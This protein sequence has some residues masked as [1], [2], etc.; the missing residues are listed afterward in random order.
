MRS[1]E[2]VFKQVLAEIRNSSRIE[3]RLRRALFFSAIVY[4]VVGLFASAQASNFQLSGR[5][6]VSPAG[7]ASYNIPLPVP[8]GTAG[9]QPSIGLAYSSGSGSGVTGIGWALTGLDSIT[10]CPQ[11]V[12][13]DGA[14]IGV[15]Y[16]DTDR[17]CLDGQRLMRISGPAYGGD[18]TV[19]RT[20]IE[21]FT[22]VIS[23]GVTGTGPTWFEVHTKAGQTM[24]FGRTGD[25]RI[26][27][28]GNP[29][30]RL[31]ALD[32]V[33]DTVGNYLTV[34][35]NNQGHASG[36]FLP[37]EIDYTGNPNVGTGQQP[38][39]AV[40]FTYTPV[41]TATGGAINP[42]TYYQ[43][44]SAYTNPFLLTTISTY[45]GTALVNNYQLTYSAGSVA[46]HA[47]LASVTACDNG[48]GANAQCLLPT[49]FGYTNGN[50]QSD[51]LNSITTGLGAVTGL[52]YESIA[53]SAAYTKGQSAQWPRI[54][55]QIPM[56]VVT[57]QDSSNGIGGNYSSTYAYQGAQADLS[58]HGFQGF[59]KVDA[60]DLQ[61]NL[62]QHSYYDQA[63]P[64]TGML[65]ARTKYSGSQIV[66]KVTNSYNCINQGPNTNDCINLTS[67][68]FL[69]EVNTTTDSSWD[70]DGTAMPVLTTT[71]DSYDL[72][73]N[74]LSITASTPDGYAKI[75]TSTYTNDT[76]NWFI[77]R[78]TDTQVK[79]TI[80]GGTSVTRESAWDYYPTV[81]LLKSETVEPN[82]P[83]LTLT[84]QY[85]Y[86]DYGN[87]ELT[88]VS[89]YEVSPRSTSV[90]WG[91]QYQGRFPTLTVNAL[92]QSEAREFDL[93]FGGNTKLTDVNGLVTTWAYDTLGRKTDETHNPTLTYPT[94]AHWSY[95]ATS[96][97]FLSCTVVRTATGQPYLKTF[98][99]MLERPAFSQVPAFNG[100]DTIV[101]DLTAYNAIGQVRSVAEPYI[102]T[103]TDYTR[104]TYDALGRVKTKTNP[105]SGV[106]TYGYSGLVT[107]VTDPLGNVTTTQKDSQ[108]QVVSVTDATGKSSTYTYKPFG[109]VDTV[110]DPAGN[111]ATYQYDIR[112]RATQKVDPDL[113]LWQYEYDAL[114]QVEKQTDAKLQVTTFTYDTLSR[115]TQR[116]EPDLTS[117]WTYDTQPYGVGKLA[118]TS[119]DGDYS[120]IE[121]YDSYGRPSIT[122]I[123]VA[124][125]VYNVTSQY[126]T[127]SRVA[128]VFY[129]AGTDVT[130]GNRFTV[131]YNYDPTTSYLTSLT[132]ANGETALWSATAA[133]ASLNITQE[134]AGNG[135]QTIKTYDN[136]QRVKTIK[137]GTTIQNFT[138][139]RDLDGNLTDRIDAVNNYT[140]N[141]TYDALNRLCTAQINATR[142]TPAGAGNPCPTQPQSFYPGQSTTYS[143]IGNL[144]YKS[145][146]GPYHYPASGA[147]SSLPHAVSQIGD[148]NQ[149]ATL[150]N[151][152]G[153]TGVVPS[154]ATY[155]YDADGNMTNG[156]GRALA[157]TSYNMPA[158]IGSGLPNCTAAGANTVMF[159]YDSDHR[160]YKEIAPAP[161]P[162]WTLVSMP[163]TGLNATVPAYH[164]ETRVYIQTA[165]GIIARAVISSTGT[166]S[167]SSYFG[168]GEVKGAYQVSSGT[169]ST[170]YY[171]HDHL[172]SV[173]ALTGSDGGV[174]ARYS[175]DAWGKFRNH[176]GS[177]DPFDTIGSLVMQ[178][179]TGQEDLNEVALINL[180]ARVYD[181]QIGK[182]TSAD[183]MVGA[184][185]GTQGWNRY[186]YA[187]NNPLVYTDPTGMCFLGCFWKQG[188]FRDIVG[189]A[190]AFIGQEYL[191]PA[192]FGIDGIGAAIISGAAAGGITSGSLSGVLTGGIE[193]GLFFEVGT[194]T[195]GHFDLGT[196]AGQEAAAKYFGT[197]NFFENVAGHAVVGG[198]ANLANGASFQSGFVAA[199]FS[200]F[201]GPGLAA[202][203][204]DGLVEEIIAGGIGSELGGGKFESGA[205]T[206]AFGYLFNENGCS[207]FSGKS[208]EE[209]M[210]PDPKKQWLTFGAFAS[211]TVAPFAAAGVVEVGLDGAG[212]SVF[213]SGGEEALSVARPLG[214]TL[215]QT[216]IGS[217]LNWVDQYVPVPRVVW[218]MSSR[219]FADNATGEATAVIR[220]SSP[221]SIWNTIEKPTLNSNNVPIN[222]K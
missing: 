105:D 163:G 24:E 49:A 176:D 75:T 38:Y 18:G 88:Q 81:G 174:L 172:G 186:A 15:N 45:V 60:T 33:T 194:L 170:T 184:M 67:T 98:Y 42:V 69:I 169:A 37:Q 219:I 4:I 58:G 16:T 216:P 97:C 61:T 134:T 193:A 111:Q 205:I 56:S 138:Y 157:Y 190:V 146:A 192:W 162:S 159:G 125:T 121:S 31:W 110:T 102:G 51:L 101:K 136:M 63:F 93:R 80:P 73:G 112:G 133:N 92:G 203:N 27:A 161:N 191:L 53:N 11:T 57:R 17:F 141:F 130:G 188:W 66:N 173:T 94:T 132:N 160:R 150:N 187:G 30:A 158:C 164:S 72:F 34:S 206:G 152:R 140:E 89:G 91:T 65:S 41:N 9:M 155:S 198:L 178:T 114:S 2:A 168:V 200:D 171:H 167:W 5:F 22:E 12:A 189:I 79:A 70:L 117:T 74:P 147:G 207:S 151:G 222:Y 116:V 165:A 1:M 13:Q 182:F 122:A 85:Y 156:G 214:T 208:Y 126:D 131:H 35:Y 145:D 77:G 209:C 26:L 104:Y 123:T 177:A 68:R 118:T 20:E 137:T 100:T 142:A 96:G 185:F 143:T 48:V 221:K 106:I 64:L 144:N 107:S 202:E 166:V 120:R 175:Y 124:G 52:T 95:S 8:P 19:Y 196:Q 32:R 90:T 62:L 115:I 183:P 39:A 59:A 43:A 113:G 128:K 54:D 7:A 127:A 71:Y 3:R 211:I 21:T 47:R 23:H 215:D 195:N 181:P 44:G 28:L 135:V 46:F 129:P 50:G 204:A 210:N 217:F 179:Y 149:P 83:T 213:W 36:Y 40:K 99:D 199:G 6:N 87:K 218:Q 212:T 10:R 103:A 78:V 108:S 197:V 180:N 86:D 119:T 14:K 153:T 220:N 76:T 201:V 139:D 84:T 82:N 154:P 148:A 29:T 25:S 55:L 109:L